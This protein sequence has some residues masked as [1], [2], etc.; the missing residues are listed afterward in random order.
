MTAPNDVSAILQSHLVLAVTTTTTST[1]TTPRGSKKK[2]PAV[3]RE[4]M[5]LLDPSK[6]T[7]LPPVEVTPESGVPGRRF[8]IDPSK[9][10]RA[11]EWA[12]FNNSA[13][14][15]QVKLSH[16]QRKP[17]VVDD[18]AFARFNKAPY[19]PP[20]VEGWASLVPTDPR[21]PNAQD[22]EL[23]FALCVR[24]DLRWPV[25][26]DR[27][28]PPRPLVEL[29]QRYYVVAN[30][31][32]ALSPPTGQPAP[33]SSFAVMP[34][35]AAPSVKLAQQARAAL[36]E[37]KYDPVSEIEHSTRLDRQFNKSR[38]E[39]AEETKL[40]AEF[41][42]V[43]AELKRA[44]HTE[45]AA[46]PPTSTT[47]ATT[48]STLLEPAADAMQAQTCYLRSTRMD[49]RPNAVGVG[50]RMTKKM[51]D[52]MDLLGVPTTLLPSRSVATA[53]NALRL[54]AVKLLALQKQKTDKTAKLA[55]L[56]PPP[57]VVAEVVEAQQPQSAAATTVPPS[58]QPTPP[59]PPPPPPPAAPIVVAAPISPTPPPIVV[60]APAPTATTPELPT[61]ATNKK[62]KSAST[63]STNN[64]NKKKKKA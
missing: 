10:T 4:V 26:H 37:F 50:K 52:L 49:V 1:T 11:W 9:K 44:L 29:K 39:E 19:V 38:E 2:P 7:Q 28:I 30:A 25:V 12:P 17:V 8:T 22:T 14:A 34:R 43:E 41:K 13:R 47:T 57:V 54:D 60:I 31:L 5:A 46:P 56:S 6:L 40:A 53:F 55:S 51:A 48:T 20:L 27:F 58:P 16:W 42:R 18:Y 32:C 3:S 33:L 59:P 61:E 21:W 36:A 23:L 24:Y 62:R 35:T 45:R 63:P 64:N 15:D